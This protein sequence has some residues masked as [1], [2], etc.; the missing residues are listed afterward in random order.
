MSE[1]ISNPLLTLIREQGLIDD[2][3]YAGVPAGVLS[4]IWQHELSAPIVGV[5]Q[6]LA[7]ARQQAGG[8]ECR[9]PSRQADAGAAAHRTTTANIS[10]M[11]FLSQFMV[12]RSQ[13][14]AVS[15][16]YQAV[17]GSDVDHIRVARRLQLLKIN[18]SDSLN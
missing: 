16:G 14:P 3:Q 13:I 4:W 11:P 5:S 9:V 12:Y 10:K 7:M 17:R 8:L 6:S 2:L 18:V 1:E 15:I